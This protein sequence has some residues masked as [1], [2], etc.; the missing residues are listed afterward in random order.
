MR[1]VDSADVE[2]RPFFGPE[3][4]GEEFTPDLQE[5]MEEMHRTVEP[6]S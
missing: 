5:R 3:D 1:D 6:K 2:L 4:F